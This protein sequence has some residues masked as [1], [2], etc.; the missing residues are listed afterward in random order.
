MYDKCDQIHSFL[1]ISSH[2]TEEILSGKLHFWSIDC[3]HMTLT[4]GGEFRKGGGDLG[5]C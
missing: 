5:K 4:T 2:F 1:R 3:S